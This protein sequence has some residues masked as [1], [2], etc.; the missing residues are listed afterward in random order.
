[1][2]PARR[3]LA[4]QKS[5]ANRNWFSFA[6]CLPVTLA[7]QKLQANRNAVASYSGPIGTLAVQ[8]S[9]ANRNKNAFIGRFADGMKS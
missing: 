3:T 8:K 5:Q 9:Q 4:V 6:A 1:M 2:T 7:V